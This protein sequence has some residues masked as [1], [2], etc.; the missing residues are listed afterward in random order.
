MLYFK[1]AT[2]IVCKVLEECEGTC[3]SCPAA[4]F[5]ISTSKVW[6]EGDL[7]VNWFDLRD[8]PSALRT[9]EEIHFIA[10]NNC[11]RGR[12]VFNVPVNKEL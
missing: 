10:I 7:S 6:I 12:F 8:L 4:H 11:L 2:K 9:A 5:F 1:N 3:F